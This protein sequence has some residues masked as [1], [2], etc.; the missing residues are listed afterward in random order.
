M[1]IGIR[2]RRASDGVTVETP[3]TGVIH[4]TSGTGAAAVSAEFPKNTQ[5]AGS[6]IDLDQ[7]CCLLRWYPLCLWVHHLEKLRLLWLDTNA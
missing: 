3:A 2:D 5:Y 7:C 1:I 6:A 4:Q